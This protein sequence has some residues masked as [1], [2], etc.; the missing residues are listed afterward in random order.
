MSKFRRRL[1]MTALSRGSDPFLPIESIYSYT[2]AVQQATLSP[3][4]YI[5]ECWGAQGGSYQTNYGGY[6]GYSKGTLI[7]ASPSRIYIYVGGQ[8]ATNS[9]ASAVTTGGWNGGGNGANRVYSGTSSYGQG[10]GGASDIRIGSTS[11]YARVI[12]AGGGGGSA[13]NGDERTSKHGGGTR[14]GSG[15]AN[16]TGRYIAGQTAP[17]T[18]SSYK[19]GTFGV[20]ASAAT[21]RLN[22][23]YGSGGGGGGWYGGFAY[24]TA[25]D[26]S[27]GYRGYNGGGSGYVY[28]S[29]NV[30]DY[31]SGCLLN[32]A[33]YLADAETHSGNEGGEYS[34]TGHGL[35]KITQIA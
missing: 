34:R 29:A 2:G 33:H 21:S 11:L 3:G 31:P 10:G 4:T 20:G 35:V 25:S 5:L 13:S 32:T 22:Y 16:A 23:K 18:Q 30:S 14:G 19:A 24:N 1:M 6:G 26:S 28:T 15:G 27:V 9:T 12:V 8:P 7:I 17:S